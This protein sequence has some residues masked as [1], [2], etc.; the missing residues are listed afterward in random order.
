MK[1]ALFKSA[2]AI[3]AALVGATAIAQP[4]RAFGSWDYVRDSFHDSTEAGRPVGGTV[5]EIYGMAVKQAGDTVTVAINS[6]FGVGGIDDSRASSGNITFGDL[7]LNFGGTQYGVRFAEGNE[8]GVSGLGLYE[9]ITTKDTTSTNYGWGKISKYENR[10]A[11]SV[12]AGESLYGDL[13][14]G[15]DYFGKRNKWRKA[16]IAIGSGTKVEN[17]NFLLGDAVDLAGLD[18]AT[19]LGATDLGSEIVAF[20]FTRTADMVG[21]FT[22]HIFAECFNDGVALKGNL[23]PE[24]PGASTPEPTGIAALALLGLGL[25]GARRRQTA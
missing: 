21:D 22:A 13:D 9:G 20:S 10:V 11:G 5:Y 23:S 7:I 16:A 2:T 1:P 15:T 4:A 14:A 18:F 24:D 6:N 12:Q 25:A 8:S 3:A 17:D 19:G